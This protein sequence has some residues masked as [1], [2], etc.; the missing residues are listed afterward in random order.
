VGR[1]WDWARDSKAVSLVV[2]PFSH[3]GN[4]VTLFRGKDGM[5]TAA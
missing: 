5:C 2:S 4:L 3:K 1:R